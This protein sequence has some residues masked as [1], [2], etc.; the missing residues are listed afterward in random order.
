[1]V[2]SS[3]NRKSKEPNILPLDFPTFANMKIRENS[4]WP[5][6]DS[7]VHKQFSAEKISAN[8]FSAICH[9]IFAQNDPGLFYGDF[10]ARLAMV[11]FFFAKCV[12]REAVNKKRI[13]YFFYDF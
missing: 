8:D 5:F 7:A 3:L 6:G 13:S 11:N 10:Y 1:M 4:G 12:P 2:E 9:S